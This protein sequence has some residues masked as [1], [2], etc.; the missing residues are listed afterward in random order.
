MSE[1]DDRAARE[2]ERRRQRI[3]EEE[4]ER[5]RMIAEEED[6]RRQRDAG[7]EDR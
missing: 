7:R 4:R 2:A 1:A 5:N 6:R 3:L